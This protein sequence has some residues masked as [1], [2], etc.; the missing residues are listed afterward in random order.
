MRDAALVLDLMA[1]GAARDQGG[2]YVLALGNVGVTLG[3]LAVGRVGL[4]KDRM[5]AA[6]PPDIPL[7]PKAWN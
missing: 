2:V 5:S 4:E 3:A 1:A 6:V 7:L